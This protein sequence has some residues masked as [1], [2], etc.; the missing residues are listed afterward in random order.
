MME[1]EK[2]MKQTETPFG[3]TS[4]AGLSRR[5][6]LGSM[7]ATALGAASLT[8]LAGCSQPAASNQ[9]KE[10]GDDAT[11][12]LASGNAAFAE[13]TYTSTQHTPYAIAE[14]TCTFDATGLTSASYA[15]TA[16]S[17]ND[18][19]PLFAPALEQMCET[20]A[21]AGK[22]AG[23]DAVSGATFCSNAIL[24]GIDSCTLQALGVTLPRPEQT[25]PQQAGYDS[26]NGTCDKV[27]SPIKLGI[28][29]LP[30]R[31]VKSAGSGVWADAAGDKV[32]VAKELYGAMAENG[33]SLNLLAGGNLSGLGILPDALD[34]TTGTL[35]EALAHAAELTDA[36]HA[37]GGKVGFQMCFGGLAPSVPD[38][39]INETPV[40]DLDAF[41]DRVGTSAER[42]KSAGFDCIEIKG[43]S[44]D[45]LNGFLTRRV[46][47]REDEYGPQ[48]IENRTRLFTRMIQ[49]IKEVNGDDFPVGALINGV[50]ENDSELGD[51]ELFM[52]L[53]EGIE[54]AKAMEAAGA[55]W[56]QVRVGAKSGEMNIW[57]PDVQ[58]IA[59]SADGLTGYGTVFDYGSHFDGTV[60][61][62]RSGFAS[63]LPIVTAIK[64][65]VSVPVGCAACLDLRLGPD[66]INDAI[67]DGKLD[68]VFM[69]RPLNCDPELVAKIQDGRREDVRPCMKC[70]HCHDN[71][72][73][74][75]EVPSTCRMNASSFNSLTDVMPEGMVPTPAE[76]ARNIMVVGA[77]PAG[78]EAA[79]VAAERGHSVSL[80]DSESTLGGL[81]PFAQGVK[82]NHERFDDYLAYI[83]AQLEKK[84]VDMHLGTTVDAALVKQQ[85][86]DAVV[87]ATGGVRES[88][89]SGANVFAAK[90][91]FSPAVLGEKVVVL[92]ASVQ[93]IDFAAFL[94]SQG[95]AVT[96]LNEGSSSALD[97]GQ[98]GWFKSYMLPYL[99]SNGVQILSG[100]TVESVDGAG[101]TFKTDAGLEKTVPCDSVVELYDMQPNTALA[102]ELEKAGVEVYTVGDAAE[103]RN[104]QHAV[105]TGNLCARAL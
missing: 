32:S 40:E 102:D 47:K 80:Y 37:G 10:D 90:D 8:T 69:N 61:G 53:E 38:S 96:V 101:V 99:R 103:P 59:P 100:V 67:A 28:M 65:H 14:V 26:F 75:K 68:L 43:A 39:V 97:R 93:A 23:V 57:A 91:A 51:N 16:T 50:E 11:T 3:A 62:S 35:E 48:S 105:T 1:E 52:T 63:F 84:Q 70:M 25:N 15:V 55:D 56:I 73:T 19:F 87:V 89:F 71:I 6:F 58:H 34:K 77:G 27:F 66:Y 82:G 46:N 2:Q 76:K 36:I 60:D 104:I 41:I 49:K 86:P 78:M 31:V 92:G 74:N 22:T 95:K 9:P 54:I 5:G 33:V 18:Y 13:G 81:I 83:A 44:A 88:R 42:A 24:D 17:D 64:Q 72:G 7:A 85:A 94:V 98:S 45:A 21:G 29:E 4:Q 20:V 30:N 12:A 79:R